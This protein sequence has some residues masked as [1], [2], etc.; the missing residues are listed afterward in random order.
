MAW[1][2]LFGSLRGYIPRCGIPCLTAFPKEKKKIVCMKQ[3][4]ERKAGLELFY[5]TSI[6]MCRETVFDNHT[7][8][9]LQS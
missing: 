1:V 9:Y 5:L 2:K 4:V 8:P 6:S 7:I 3:H